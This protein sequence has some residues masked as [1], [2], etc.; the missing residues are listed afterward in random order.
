MNIK[1]KIIVTEIDRIKSNKIMKNLQIILTKI[2][3]T[4]IIVKAFLPLNQNNHHNYK[5]DF[6]KTSNN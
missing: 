5:Y 3:K 2:D 6:F 1:I 4:I